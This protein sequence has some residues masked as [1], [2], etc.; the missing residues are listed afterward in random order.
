[1][2][3]SLDSICKTPP[4]LYNLQVC[5][6]WNETQK[7]LA[8]IPTLYWNSYKVSVGK[9]W[10]FWKA[11]TNH[12]AAGH[13]LWGNTDAKSAF[14]MANLWGRM[15]E[16]LLLSAIMSESQKHKIEW[17]K[18]DTNKFIYSIYI[19][20][21]EVKLSSGMTTQDSNVFGGEAQG[22]LCGARTFLKL[23]RNV[24]LF[25]DRSGWAAQLENPNHQYLKVFSLS[26]LRDVVSKAWQ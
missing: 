3:R 19:K 7:Q 18:P 10:I 24:L 2:S 14:K 4:H 25:L 8:W 1:M 6:T 13:S 9:Q 21:K 5:Q 26:F 16:R 22:H 23:N 20:V 17:K 15:N 11:D 12:R